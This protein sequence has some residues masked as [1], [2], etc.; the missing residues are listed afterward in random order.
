M[1][2]DFQKGDEGKVAEIYNYYVKNTVVTF[3]ESEVT[4]KDIESRVS[5]VLNSNLPWLIYE[6]NET[7]VGYAYASKWKERSAYRNS[8]E[9]TVYLSPL[10]QGC[11][12]GS[13]L[14]KALFSRLKTLN[15][16]AA[17]GG[18]TLPN[19]ASVAL[20]EKFGMKKVAHFSEVGFKFDRYL[21]VGYWQCLLSTK[22]EHDNL[23]FAQK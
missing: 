21:D 4:E 14:Y 16:H 10:D 17:M 2:R 9:I 13:E 22:Q 19:E 7:V 1:I 11:G 23:T 15:I 6:K 20:H 18:I 3:E 8:V 5:T 12:F